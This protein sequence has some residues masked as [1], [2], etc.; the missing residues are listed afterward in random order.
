MNN[1]QEYAEY[2]YQK[3]FVIH[4]IQKHWLKQVMKIELEDHKVWK[5]DN[6]CQKKLSKEELDW[7]RDWNMNLSNC[8][9]LELNF[10]VW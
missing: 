7:Q 4:V 9:A 10:F 2:A 6:E 1:I 5:V 8:I 3:Y